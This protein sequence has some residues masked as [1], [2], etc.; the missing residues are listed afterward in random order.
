VS[1]HALLS[2]IG[3]SL[4][5][6]P[7]QAKQYCV[8]RPYPR[9]SPGLLDPEGGKGSRDPIAD[10]QEVLPLAKFA[11]KGHALGDPECDDAPLDLL[12]GLSGQ[13]RTSADL[14]NWGAEAPQVKVFS[15]VRSEFCR[16]CLQYP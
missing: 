3:G 5:S 2:S 12:A 16:V 13:F 6:E 1:A 11:L 14:R 15:L 7:L 4:L 10:P 8:G 9:K